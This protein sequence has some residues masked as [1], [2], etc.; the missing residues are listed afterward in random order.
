MRRCLFITGTGTDVGK[1][2]AT[3]ALLHALRF[4]GIRAAGMKPVQTGA[5]CVD[6]YWR[7]PD[8]DL[9]LDAMGESVDDADYERMAPYRYEPACSPHLA[10]RMAGRYPELHRILDCAEG[11]LERYDALLVEGAGGILA[12][13]DEARLMIDLAVAL[14]CPAIVVAST[15]LGTIN[16]S[17]LT[18]R[19]LR[20]A[21]APVT[22][23]VFN[24]QQP[25][26]PDWIARDNPET[27]AQLG[28]APVLG[29]LSHRP[30]PPHDWRAWAGELT[31][32]D[33]VIEA[34]Q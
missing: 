17:L 10:G 5:L 7:A 22:G 31:G 1:T 2:I 14:D 16:H 28:G 3:G 26:E 30:S 23:L 18:L 6:G 33:R 27:I 19:E 11:L 13:L 20:R 12:P 32:L 24:E 25:G 8:L 4:R 15:G 29:V 9:H 21:G 34:L